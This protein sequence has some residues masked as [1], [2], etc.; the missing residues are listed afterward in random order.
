MSIFARLTLTAGLLAGLATGFPAGPS[1]AQQAPTS[2]EPT[3][4]APAVDPV[5]AD[6]TQATIHKLNAYV[7]L[8]NRTLR[9][10][11]SLARY[12]SWVDMKKGLTGHERLVY[13][14]YGLYDVRSE[15]AKAEAA[16]TQ[17]PAMPE[18][19]T[20]MKAY[21]AA[22]QALAPVITEADGYYERE[23]Y[24]TDKFAQGKVLHTKLADAGPAF[25]AERRK[26]DVLFKAEKGKS[27]LAELAAIEARE[28]R[29][30]RWHV[31]NVMIEARKMVDLLPSGEKPV[32]DMAVFEA[33]LAR[34]ADVVKSMDA[35]GAANPD[36]FFTFED[37]PRSWL[38]KLRE[39]DEK[40]IHAKG[41]AR[42]G[43]IDL[44]WIVNDYNT[45]VSS[46]ESATSFSH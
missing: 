24:R 13:G 41:D 40:L 39:L 4:P 45:M 34:Y 14:L 9:A 5:P 17:P 36:S 25:L 42:R 10:Q 20:E 38:G 31:V 16:L 2:P 18:L 30:A 32:V 3:A 6:P 37:E 33:E 8:L 29:K 12:A 43:R 1:D 23:D 35:Y 44:T 26:V 46:S 15:I 11:E 19:D 28:G 22:Y 27:D 21:I 7:E